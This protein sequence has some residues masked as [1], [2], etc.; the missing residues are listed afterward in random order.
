M[1]IKITL[2]FLFIMGFVNAQ[3]GIKEAKKDLEDLKTSFNSSEKKLSQAQKT[4]DSIKTIYNPPTLVVEYDFQTGTYTNA[5]LKP[6]H[7]QPVVLKIININK[8]ANFVKIEN[9]DV[10]ISNHLEPDETEAKAALENNKP[11]EAIIPKALGVSVPI[12]ENVINMAKKT[13][14][15]QIDKSNIASQS[16]LETKNIAFLDNIA[17][18][19]LELKI[20][21]FDLKKA[22]DA[23]E[24]ANKKLEVMNID[25]LKSS[26]YKLK[27][28]NI[29]IQ[30]EL[31]NLN[32]ERLKNQNELDKYG[33]FSRNFKNKTNKLTEK[34]IAFN[35]CLVN[36]NRINAAYS[37]Y[38]DFVINSNLTKIQYRDGATNICAILNYDKRTDYYIYVKDFEKKYSEFLSQYNETFNI[39]LFYEIIKIDESYANLVKLKFD[40]VKTEVEATNTLVNTSELRKKLNNV[41]LIDHVLKQDNAFEVVSNPIQPLEDYIEFKVKITPNKDLGTSIIK[42]QVAKDFTYTE[43][44]R[45]GVRWDFSVGTVFDFGIKNQE[46]EVKEGL[47]TDPTPKTIYNIVENNTSQYTPTIAGLLHTSFR[48]NSMFAFGFSLGASIDLTSLNLN[49]FFPGISLLIGKKEKTIFTVGPAFKKVNQIKSIYD[50]NTIYDT[51][52][53]VADITSEQFKIGWF[54][55]ISYNLTSKQK[56]KIK[57]VN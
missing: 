10:K 15:D 52:I 4:L 46:Y 12:P 34:Y 6:K 23:I 54:V 26:Y 17:E 38:I 41:E 5:K 37:S 55:G 3:D 9:N 42:Q 35:S 43:Y 8:F 32:Y 50:T 22:N 47:S 27:Q 39:D 28:D 49:S 1:K 24:E 48:S 2:L 31:D 45:Q 51:S 30:N 11:S 19:E 53:Q 40:N 29:T 18:K 25:S 20:N 36:I 7:N 13:E 21:E 14:K 56:S 57:V 33:D 16:S 44:V